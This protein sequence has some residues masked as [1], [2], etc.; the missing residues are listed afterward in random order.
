MMK[1][2]YFSFFA[3]LSV[4]FVQAQ[5]VNIIDN[6]YLSS[7]IVIGTNN[8]H[9]SETIY[10][11]S[12]IGANF[13]SAGTAINRISF[14]IDTEGAPTDVANY[15]VW[16]KNVPAGTT[17]FTSGAY[18][19][20]GY[21]QVFSGTYNAT[22]FLA[23]LDLTTPFVRTA[24]TNLQILIERLDGTTHPGY[25]F[26]SS[27]GNDI[28]PDVTNLTSR[29]YNGAAA[30]NPG[31]TSLTASAFRPAI[32]LIH[33]F[34]TDA[35]ITN[36][37]SP[38]VTCYNTNQSVQVELTNVGTDPIS[39]GAAQVTLNITGP[40]TFS[41]TTSN[42]TA[43]A[44]GASE[45]L[46]FSN[47]NLNNTG[48]SNVE[49]FVTLPG[50]GDLSN[51]SLF[52]S[53]FSATTLNTYPI[54]ED[55]E[56]TFPSFGYID[57][58]AGDR[59]LW[60]LQVGK[61]ANTD[62]VDSLAPRAPGNRFFIFDSYSGANSEGYES[63]LYSNCIAMPVPLPPNP[64]PVTT[65]SFWMS[66]DNVFPTSLDSLFVSVST[67]RGQSW[68]RLAGYQ[69][70]NAASVL[71]EW[72][73]KV[74]DVSA[75]NGQTVQFAFEGL[76]K[77]GNI[78]GLDDITINFTGLAPVSLLRFDAARQGRSNHL[79]W[80]TSLEV[81]SSHFVVERSS[82][83]REFTAIGQVDASGNSQSAR[84]YRF[85]DA[86]PLKGVNYYRIRMIDTDNSYKFSA[87]KSVR[88][89][90]LTEMSVNPNPVA[91]TMR[92]NLQTDKAEKATLTINELSGRRVYQGSLAVVAGANQFAIP[93]ATLPSGTYVVTLR[94]AS[95][96]LIQRITK[97]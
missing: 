65:L 36:F 48:E 31:V 35:A 39:A 69:R 27:A 5:T 74:I 63:R 64:A 80:T 3:L 45:F 25:I 94:L 91:A 84:D 90:G 81:N 60:D 72:V 78:I 7:N 89:T 22:G 87:V 76:S 26:L 61:Y 11:N 96:T 1:K 16:M 53:V 88:N 50:D 52:T 23:S 56:T 49:T 77:Y 46:T 51:D 19:R 32:Q 79:N 2:F 57:I 70:Y 15:N 41:S 73:Q 71:P 67:D 30:P 10:T 58:I 92:L 13:T 34:A 83:G 95:Q 93:T 97:Q 28:L 24:G 40:N 18:S 86:N 68:T 82:D 38:V 20:T 9:A 42:T 37:I 85:I 62:Q 75:Y 12:E 44:P 43:L 17:T 6:L 55:A 14:L 47:I 21:T 29:R 54:V 8:Y 59:Q 4:C 33:V 66:N